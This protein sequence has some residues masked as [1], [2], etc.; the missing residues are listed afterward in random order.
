MTRT[1]GRK[2]P[3]NAGLVAID[4]VFGDVPGWSEAVQQARVGNDVAHAIHD[5]R[6][7]HG[8]TQ[9]Q[10]AARVGTTQSV[11]ARL[12][13]A[14]YEGHS[15]RMLERIAAAVGSRLHIAFIDGPSSGS[16]A[17]R[18]AALARVGERGRGYP[19]R[20]AGAV[21]KRRRSGS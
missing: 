11:I 1:P 3:T 8:L 20:K 12:E 4:D 5:L 17:A 21:P 15:L 16:G 14:G 9:Q 10:L 13:D 19:T 2:R 7:R 6:K 18:S